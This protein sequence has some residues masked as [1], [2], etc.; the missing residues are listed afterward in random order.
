V[1]RSHSDAQSTPMMVSETDTDVSRPRRRS[2]P[3]P[4]SMR[5][6]QV[7]PLS[8]PHHVLESAHARA[9]PAEPPKRSVSRGTRGRHDRHPPLGNARSTHDRV[10]HPQRRWGKGPH[11]RVAVHAPPTA[12]TDRCVRARSECGEGRSAGGRGG[13][14]RGSTTRRALPAR[15]L[16]AGACTTTGSQPPP[17]GRSPRGAGAHTGQ[18]RLPGVAPVA[19]PP[20]PPR[21]PAAGPRR[22]SPTAAAWPTASAS[23]PAATASGACAAADSPLPPPPSPPHQAGL[24]NPTP[25]GAP[26]WGHSGGGGRARGPLGSQFPHSRGGERST[27]VGLP[28]RGPL[29]GAAE[30]RMTG[31]LLFR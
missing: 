8:T 24:C 7:Y 17:Q 14:V 5:T 21:H 13:D 11:R 20:T 12:A 26:P 10:R 4:R 30:R 31:G 2:T 19:L 27:R 23:V 6:D 22:G 9:T 1:P 29:E 25:T 18:R 28:R 15:P 3:P 16:M